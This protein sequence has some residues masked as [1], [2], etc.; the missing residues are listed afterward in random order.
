MNTIR[1][2]LLEITIKKKD[3]SPGG[4]VLVED[5]L[6]FIYKICQAQ[7]KVC[8]DVY[9]NYKNHYQSHE[10]SIETLTKDKIKHTIICAPEPEFDTEFND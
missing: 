10:S 5:V 2:A 3:G 4:M 8:A 6:P 1:D 9:Y 7:R